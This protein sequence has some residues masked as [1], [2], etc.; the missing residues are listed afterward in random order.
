MK[1]KMDIAKETGKLESRQVVIDEWELREDSEKPPRLI[2]YASVFDQ[3]AEIFGMWREKITPG[4][5]K[6]TI[7]ENDI[8]AL[9]NH[10][11]DIV[12]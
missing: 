11:T 4:A 8:R 10:N 2:G 12:L 1:T 3:E 9:W 6:K 7:S 5:Y